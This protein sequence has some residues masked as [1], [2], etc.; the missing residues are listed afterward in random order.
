MIWL[1]WRQI[2]LQALIAAGA[3]AAASIML[4]VVGLAMRDSYDT[5]IAPCTASCDAVLDAFKRQYA[6]FVYLTAAAVVG[7]PALLGVFWGA[8]LVAR[9]FETGTY[10]MIW[11]QT[12]SRGRWL[13]IKLGLVALLAVAVTGALTL[14]L[15]WAADP[16]DTLEGSKFGI[17]SFASRGLTPFAYALFAVV[18]GITAGLVIRRTLPA[19]AV[20]LLVFAVLQVA[21][22]LGIREHLATPVTQALAVNQESMSEVNGVGMKDLSGGPENIKPDT[23]VVLSGYDVPGA[24]MLDAEHPILRAD[25]TPADATKVDYCIRTG[26]DRG[27]GGLGGAGDCLSKLNLHIDLRYHP[28]DRYWRFQLTE[29]G[30]FAGLA[31]AMGGFCLWRIRRSLG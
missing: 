25:G 6:A 13:A 7:L 22:P 23:Q 19:M 18:L 20:T 30:I 4:L 3:V 27:S 5:T 8:P 16:F 17:F 28:A 1:T 26:T 31:L 14:V 21:M 2:R 12:V 29:S 10:R 15:G 9:E 11:N 24:W